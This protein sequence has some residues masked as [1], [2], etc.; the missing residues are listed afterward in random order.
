MDLSAIS[1]ELRALHALIAWNIGGSPD[2]VARPAGEAAGRPRTGEAP[3]EGGTTNA[4]AVPSAELIRVGFAAPDEPTMRPP[5]AEEPADRSPGSTLAGLRPPSPLAALPVL[6]LPLRAA[7]DAEPHRGTEGSAAPRT[8]PRRLEVP[9][10]APAIT[11]AGDPASVPDG[12]GLAARPGAVASPA[13]TPAPSAPIGEN[14]RLPSMTPSSPAAPSGTEADGVSLMPESEAGGPRSPFRTPAG[15]SAGAA[16]DAGRANAAGPAETVAG[17]RS[18]DTLQAGHARIASAGA[19]A[20]PERIAT[21]PGAKSDGGTTFAPL[22]ATSNPIVGAPEGTDPVLSSPI[23]SGP[24]AS[25]GPPPGGALGPVLE[26]LAGGAFVEL[27]ARA[28]SGQTE[29]AGIIASFILNAAMIPGWPP[30]R[31]IEP[32][33]LAGP[34]W[35]KRLAQAEVGE[36]ELLL[37]L[38]LRMQMNDPDRARRIFEALAPARRRSK[39]LALLA[40]LVTG[41]KT[42]VEHLVRE[43][44]AIAED[45]AEDALSTK[46]RRVVL[47]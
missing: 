22:R 46:G 25:G 10:I 11:S 31:P 16:P 19:S 34:Q 4:R 26:L 8:A 45:R 40:V 5:S 33:S 13:F 44:E 7:P 2:D 28:E 9:A 41:V 3:A 20:G 21:G 14:S 12:R 43:L 36:D 18:G 42:V 17:L 6:P 37:L 32:A 38:L 23:G 24:L 30:P 15:T 39:L 35:A 27:S 47:R 29:R 1:S